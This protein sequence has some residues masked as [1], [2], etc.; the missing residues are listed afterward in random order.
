M[1]EHVCDGHRGFNGI[2]QRFGMTTV[3][4]DKNPYCDPCK[5]FDSKA[6]KQRRK[7]SSLKSSKTL[8]QRVLQC[9]HIDKGFMPTADWN[10][11]RYFQI[12]V[13]VLSRKMWEQQLI[14]KGQDF[15]EFEAW[16]KRMLAEKPHLKLVDVV[17][18][19]EYD[20]ENFN[21]LATAH[22]FRIDNKSPHTGKA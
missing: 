1:Y 12:I 11:S 7:P 10:G 20:K 5:Q 9:I 2:R 14:T 22:G 3:D 4:P 18:D 15:A 6:Q 21:E 19:N 13:D 16:L 17:C 8:V